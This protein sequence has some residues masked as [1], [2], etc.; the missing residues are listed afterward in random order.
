MQFPSV[1]AGFLLLVPVFR[2]P[3]LNGR[4]PSRLAGS[5]N[6]VVKCLGR[7]L[8]FSKEY[9]P[10]PTPFKRSHFFCPTR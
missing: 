6:L 1:L 8:G 5:R 3:K 9:P 2:I 4:Y 7:A 10:P